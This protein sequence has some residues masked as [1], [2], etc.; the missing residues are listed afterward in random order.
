MKAH[1]IDI[2]RIT[3]KDSL[4]YSVQPTSISRVQAGGSAGQGHRVYQVQLMY[5]GG[6]TQQCYAKLGNDFQVQKEFSLY[7][8]VF[9]QEVASTPRLLGSLD[10]DEA[11]CLLLESVSGTP[12]NM[13][14]K[15]DVELVFRRY[16][17]FH[18]Q[19]QPYVS[20]LLRGVG[21]TKSALNP[22]LMFSRLAKTKVLCDFGLTTDDLEPFHDTQWIRLV[23]D[24]P[25]TLVHGD[26]SP[27]NVLITPDHRDVH[28]IDFGLSQLHPGSSEFLY[29]SLELCH[30]YFPPDLFEHGLRVYWAEGSR[31]VSFDEFLMRQMYWSASYSADCLCEWDDLS[32]A[33]RIEHRNN[34]E[35]NA[36]LLRKVSRRA[37][38]F[39]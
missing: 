24:E 39:L 20:R 3:V 30:A 34:L 6:N 8:D 12:F 7:R 13:T 18:R 33:R 19:C 14:S 2:I 23:M 16:A 10:H 27:E 25:R 15:A 9:S 4:G 28:L 29:Y 36:I 1:D 37:R 31:D 5:A 22:T 26:I 11:K 38:G 32:E 21:S 17:V 35:W